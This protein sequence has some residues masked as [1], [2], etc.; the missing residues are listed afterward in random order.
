MSCPKHGN[1]LGP[2]LQGHGSGGQQRAGTY[3][4]TMLCWACPMSVPAS[5]VRFTQS[6]E[7]ADLREW[8]HKAQSPARIFLNSGFSSLGPQHTVCGMYVNFPHKACQPKVVGTTAVTSKKSVHTSEA[9][10]LPIT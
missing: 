7:Q 2:G 5:H 9:H 8:Q 1:L 4:W 3:Y 10:Q 6:L